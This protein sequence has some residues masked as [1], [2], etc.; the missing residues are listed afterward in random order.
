MPGSVVP[1][2]LDGYEAIAV[3]D[4]MHAKSRMLLALFGKDLIYPPMKEFEK[5]YK[6]LIDRSAKYPAVF[7]GSYGYYG[8]PWYY[9]Y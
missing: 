4:R 8:A 9:W 3:P 2:G 6:H 5:K 1:L 7:T